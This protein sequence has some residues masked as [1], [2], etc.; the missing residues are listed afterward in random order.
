MASKTVTLLAE[1][2]AW[3]GVY[4]SRLWLQYRPRERH[5]RSKC[6]CLGRLNVIPSSNKAGSFT[7]SL[8]GLLSG[9]HVQQS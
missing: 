8:H 5:E 7:F 1:G 2:V 6:P 4:Q 9:I 3:P